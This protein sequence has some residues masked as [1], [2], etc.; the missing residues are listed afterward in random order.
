MNL[1]L[2]IPY[3]GWYVIVDQTNFGNVDILYQTL[4]CSLA[5]LMTTNVPSN[6]TENLSLRHNI[7]RPYTLKYFVLH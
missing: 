3:R 7:V 6:V 2:K 1:C 5:T 4:V